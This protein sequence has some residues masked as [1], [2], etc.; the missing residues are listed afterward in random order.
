[1]LLTFFKW[2]EIEKEKKVLYLNADY[3]DWVYFGESSV[4]YTE[5][6]LDKNK[7]SCR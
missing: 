1:M 6:C 5:H 4:I 3:I 2:K 7:V